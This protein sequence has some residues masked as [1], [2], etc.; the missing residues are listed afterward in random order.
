M[1][2]G[3][4]LGFNKSGSSLA[5]TSIQSIIPEAVFQI[6]AMGYSGSGVLMPNRVPAPFD[7]SPK[8][9]Y[10]FQLGDG[11]TATTFPTFSGSGATAKFTTDGD[12][13]I[14]MIAA[15]TTFID[16]LH[17][18]TGGQ[19]YT[20]IFGGFFTNTG[21]TRT[22]FST[23][24]SGAT[25]GGVGQVITNL[26]AF[27]SQ[28]RGSGATVSRNTTRDTYNGVNIFCAQ[29]VA[30]GGGTVLTLVNDAS[31]SGTL[32][33]TS[34]TTSASGK[35]TLMGRGGATAPM[36]NTEEFHWAI[37][38][39]KA[40]SA[41]ELLTVQD[42]CGAFY[43]RYYSPFAPIT[44]GLVGFFDSDATDGHTYVGDAVT[45]WTDLSGAGNHMTVSG[46]V[47][48]GTRTMNGRNTF[49]IQETGYF[50]MP[51]ALYTLPAG[52]F[53]VFVVYSLDTAQNETLF[54][55]ADAT[56]DYPRVQMD[57]TGTVLRGQSG[58]GQSNFG[59]TPDT[60]N[61]IAGFVRNGATG[62]SFRDTTNG[63]AQTTSNRTCTSGRVGRGPDGE[64][65]PVDGKI[66]AILFYN[67]ALSAGDITTVQTWLK[68]RW[69]TV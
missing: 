43:S 1:R 25:N 20:F 32:T 10:D 49:D 57:F 35:P 51:S 56:L 69:G 16:A 4:G 26:E 40:L 30:A 11:V 24:N 39:A 12:D 64:L 53:T 47:F 23:L 5:D 52:D 65:N 37:M 17:K 62:Y 45:Q 41:A 8:S 14:Q 33:Y 63:T 13:Y 19:E 44:A 68:A 61:H 29:S 22:M 67:T 15:N 58:S 60:N 9:T 55:M 50:E 28:Q 21:A 46:D 27:Q 54:S 48:T 3:F 38:I 59:I 42:Y 34:S 7:G 18:T 6:D 2:L 66:S 36:A 31:E